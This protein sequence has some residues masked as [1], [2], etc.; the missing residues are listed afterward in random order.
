VDKDRV[1]L[2]KMAALFH[3]LGKPLAAAPGRSTEV[4]FYGHESQ[5]SKVVSG[6]A[7]RLRMSRK[8]EDCLT[9][10]VRHHVWP[11]HL[12][13]MA[14]VHRLSQ[15][16]K[17]RFFRRLGPLAP[18]CL[19]LALADSAAKGSSCGATEKSGSFQDFAKTLLHFD[20]TRDAAGL[21][22]PPLVSGHDL[23]RAFG[24]DPGPRIGRLLE[25]VHE[26]RVEGR[27]KTR[28]EALE[29]LREFLKRGSKI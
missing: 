15:R 23:I 13:R 11:L 21:R 29:F 2:L 3:D 1:S 9:A 8:D 19:I 4:H 7:G 5:G 18:G 24:L 10:L 25:R 16:A 14:S 28:E 20:R 27:V 17:V 26:A 12:Y 22:T 6:I